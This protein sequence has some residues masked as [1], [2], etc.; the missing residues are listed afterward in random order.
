[1]KSF[2]WIP[3]ALFLLV[4]CSKS[5]ENPDDFGNFNL[6]PAPG[7][8]NEQNLDEDSKGPQGPP[9]EGGAEGEGGLII[10]NQPDPEI[11]EDVEE[12]PA[13]DVVDQ[14]LLPAG[15]NLNLVG[16]DSCENWQEI[17]NAMGCFQTSGIAYKIVSGEAISIEKPYLVI[18]GSDRYRFIVDWHQGTVYFCPN[19]F[20]R[21]GRFIPGGGAW[22]GESEYTTT[23]VWLALC[24]RQGTSS[25]IEV[26]NREGEN[27]VSCPAGTTERASF[28]HRQAGFTTGMG[29]SGGSSSNGYLMLCE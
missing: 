11:Q 27:P 23:A 12:N 28:R 9:A 4:G 7:S 10:G 20:F 25:S 26:K 5:E 3:V 18:Q 19:G 22:V 6:K 2:F 21:R 1:M 13:A 8:S 17:P 29:A 24:V 14:N 16:V 15:V